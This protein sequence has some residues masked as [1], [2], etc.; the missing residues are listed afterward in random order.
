MSSREESGSVPRLGGLTSPA[1]GWS[2]D[3]SG[4]AWSAACLLGQLPAALG[5]EV[6]ALSPRALNLACRVPAAEC[7]DGRD[8]REYKRA[9][10]GDDLQHEDDSDDRHDHGK[11]CSNGADYRTP[12]RPG[13]VDLP[14]RSRANRPRAAFTLERARTGPPSVTRRARVAGAQAVLLELTVR[15]WTR[16]P[17]RQL[18]SV[19][20]L[21]IAS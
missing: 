20:G 7:D 19:S 10:R 17:G 18:E 8:E 5:F 9:D 2:P 12:L 21:G 15:Q 1:E 3:A 6:A 4:A 11:N 14:T 16:D 13:T